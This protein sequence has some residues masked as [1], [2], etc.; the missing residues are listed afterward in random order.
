MKPE[1][2]EIK[3]EDLPALHN[4]A[5]KASITAQGRYITL[6]VLNLF[7][8]ILGAVLTAFALQSDEAKATLASAAGISFV[9]STIVAASIAVKRYEKTW[10]GGRA[11][12]E[13]VK[14]L[15]WKYMMGAEP[16]GITLTT[17]DADERFRRDLSALLEQ[18]RYLSGALDGELSNN[19]QITD[20]MRFIRGLETG[21]RKD[22]YIKA[23]I[24]N[25]QRWYANN[26]LTNQ[27]KEWRWFLVILTAQMLAAA[28]AF[29]L[30]RWPLAPLRLS[31]VFATVAAGSIAW[32]Q[33]KRHQELAQSYNLAAHE[34]GLIAI[35]AIPI[36]T[37]EE[38]S[39]F[40]S[41]AENAISREHTMWV[42]RRD[43]M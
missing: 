29:V 17:K 12:A 19:P 33:V 9:L 21:E 39:R 11:I 6:F 25:Q 31:G 14:T 16:Y 22:L 27:I 13:S 41:D 1:S 7:L 32:L 24:E 15:A 40:V 4:A 28:S 3:K 43:Q 5:N 23:R 18:R 8:L 37:D 26:A 34:L 10:Y 36:K 30:I 42:A 2:H 35:T 38:L 20:E